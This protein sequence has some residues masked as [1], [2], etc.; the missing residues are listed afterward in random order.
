[1]FCINLRSKILRLQGR[2]NQHIPKLFRNKQ[3]PTKIF[4]KCKCKENHNIRGAAM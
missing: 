3:I 4:S 1:V 2:I